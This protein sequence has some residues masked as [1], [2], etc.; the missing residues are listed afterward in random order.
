MISA[1][2]DFVSLHVS[3]HLVT[4]NEKNMTLNVAID[5]WNYKIEM[6]INFYFK[7]HNETIKGRNNERVVNTETAD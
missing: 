3:D 4:L 2:I 5:V 1:V 7:N 6:S